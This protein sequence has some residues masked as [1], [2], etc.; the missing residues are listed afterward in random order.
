MGY[1]SDRN[2]DNSAQRFLPLEQATSNVVQ[3]HP[4]VDSGYEQPS[5]YASAPIQAD[6]EF[7]NALGQNQYTNL[8]IPQTASQAQQRRRQV[9]LGLLGATAV[10]LVLAVWLRG[11]YIALNLACDALF[12][13][14]IILL[15]RHRQIATDNARQIKPIRPPVTETTV[16]QGFSPVEY[17]LSAEARR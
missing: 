17:P 3:L 5:P 11:N 6:H 14:Y 2:I 9:L 7:H 16:Q 13:G 4:A 8:G 10:T 12:I 1:G 15:V